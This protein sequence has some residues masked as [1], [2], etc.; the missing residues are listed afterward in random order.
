MPVKKHIKEQTH[1]KFKF[2]C[3]IKIHDALCTMYTVIIY[4]FCFNPKFKKKIKIYLLDYNP[5][6]VS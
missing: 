4:T 6:C 1:A 2:I 5:Y 3:P